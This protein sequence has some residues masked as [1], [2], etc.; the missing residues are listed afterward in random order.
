MNS[1]STTKTSKVTRTAK[2]AKTTTTLRWQLELRKRSSEWFASTRSLYNQVASFYFEVIQANPS[3][4]EL[5]SKQALNSL[6]SLTHRTKLNPNPPSPLSVVANNIPAM[7]RRAAIHSAMG[8]AH[9]FQ[10]NLDKWRKKKE[11]ALARGKPFR[12]RPPVPPR[13][14]NR[15]VTLYAGMWKGRSAGQAG[16]RITIK[17]WDGNT[18]RWVRFSTQGRVVPQGCETGSP[19]VVRRGKGWWLHLPL[20]KTLTKP[21]KVADQ[22]A[23]ATISTP[24]PTHAPTATRICAVDLNINDA[25]A[26]CTILGSDGTPLATLFIGG[27]KELHGRRKR[28]L[29]MVARNRSLTG[30]IQEGVQDNK[31]LWESINHVD[32][33]FA[34]LV[35][36]RIVDFCREGGASILVFEHLGN[37]RPEKG[38]Y[39]KR[40]NEKRSYWLRG[41]IYRYSKYKAWGEGI[42]TCRVSPRNTSRHCPEC[43][44]DVARYGEGEKPE[45]YQAGAPLVY[46]PN[47][48]MR[49]N[50]DRSATL[51]IGRR[52]LARHSNKE[53]P[54]TLLR[55]PKGAG[56]SS[57]QEAGAEQGPHI[58][59]GGH[60]AANGHGTARTTEDSVVSSRSRIPR[61]LRPN[62]GSGYATHASGADYAWV[63]KDAHGL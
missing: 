16:G 56:V 18:W 37:F 23:P 19:Q 4:L 49:G 41:R 28:L 39:S 48:H 25:L 51:N 63:L 24:T 52:L 20:L 50:A 26:V 10:S 32:E 12:H 58:P 40:G 33:Q 55:S 43:G 53:K 21:Q 15:S 11:K 8:A 60:R 14:W 47:C 13:A 30:I 59:L 42:I 31:P 38:K 44:G 54:Q 5:D 45:G 27:G 2:T 36:R 7:F 3:V 17:L 35:S 6:E 29:G 22:L 34:H 61:Q 46:S 57:S 9:S 1:I 62:G